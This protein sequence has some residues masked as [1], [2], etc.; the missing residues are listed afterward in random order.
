MAKRKP[1]KPTKTK[2]LVKVVVLEYE[3]DWGQRVEE[4]RW[5]RTERSADAFV[6][7]HNAK[8]TEDT[9]PDVYWRAEKVGWRTT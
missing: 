4:I 8:N 9:V 5:F 1:L 6:E 7:K 3:R 2:P